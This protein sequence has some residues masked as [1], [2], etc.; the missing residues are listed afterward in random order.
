[1]NRFIV[2]CFCALSFAYS[3]SSA[4]ADRPPNIVFLLADDLGYG[5]VGCFGQQKIRTPNIDRLAKE[6]MKLTT[7][8]SGSPVC[9][10]SRCALMT[11]LHVGHGFIREN[12]QYKKDREGQIP[13]PAET[14]TLA[15][16]L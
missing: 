7:H 11:G 2:A 15:K 10:P 1:M 9:A 14:V 8:Y 6:G 3:I 5:D 13:I 16:L 4:A 12:R